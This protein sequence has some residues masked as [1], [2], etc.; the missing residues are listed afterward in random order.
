[1]IGDPLQVQVVLV[2][3]QYLR[4]LFIQIV[5]LLVII[6][7]ILFLLN[8]LCYL[9]NV[10]LLILQIGLVIGFIFLNVGVFEKCILLDKLFFK[11]SEQ[12]I[13]ALFKTLNMLI[14]V[15]KCYSLSY[16]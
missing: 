4:L 5:F 6:Y 1:M 2:S 15:L 3:Q 12:S 13:I 11:F 10:R 9:L 8:V 14:V 16:H 7:I